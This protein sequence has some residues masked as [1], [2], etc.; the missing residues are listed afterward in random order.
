VKKIASIF[1]TVLMLLNLSAGIV[2]GNEYQ[3][4]PGDV[5][6]IDVWG[7]ED[8][9]PK[10]PTAAGITIRPDGKISFPLVGEVAVVGMTTSQ[11]TGVLTVGLSEYLKDPKV[12]VN[13]FKFHTTR[14]YVLGEVNRPGLYEVEKQHN[15]LDAIGLAGGY[16]QDA[17]K[18][19]VFIVRKDKPGEPIK[20][21][22]LN[23]LK[24]G[25]TT[26]NVVIND[27]D[28]VYLTANGKINFAA[29]IL[30]LVSAAYFVDQVK[31]KK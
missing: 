28:V 31:N 23:L 10:D 18:K 14:I 6:L 8:L 11:L 21:N 20:A 4:Q 16:T 30:P 5:L 24:K 15:L 1:I 25:D 12:T 7:Y 19:N 26:Q 3:L 22:L 9:R 2:Q 27:G 17:A 13:V 29:D